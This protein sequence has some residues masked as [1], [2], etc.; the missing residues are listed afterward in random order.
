MPLGLGFMWLGPQAAGASRGSFKIG[1]KIASKECLLCWIVRK[2]MGQETVLV[3]GNFRWRGLASRGEG[4]IG[5][6]SSSAHSRRI[7]RSKKARGDPLLCFS[8]RQPLLVLPGHSTA[9]GPTL[10]FPGLV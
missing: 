9:Q 4:I 3:M 1:G 8:S 10:I 6:K 5:V 7:L 2:E